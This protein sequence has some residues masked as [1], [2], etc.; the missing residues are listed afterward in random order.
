MVTFLCACAPVQS[1]ANNEWK[2]PVERK[3]EVYLNI[4]TTNKFIYNMT[5]ELTKDKHYVGYMF[6]NPLQGINFKYTDDSLN[7]ISKQD[8]FIYNGVGLEP[9][10]KD[11][12]NGL[13]KSKV[14]LTSISRG[15]KLI[16]YK[17]E[18]KYGKRT[19]KDNP[20]YWLNIDDYKISIL[21]IK[22]ALQDKDPRNNTYYEKNFLEHLKN[23]EPYEKD[24]KKTL[25]NLKKYTIFFGEEELEYFVRYS[26]LKDIN[27]MVF[28]DDKDLEEKLSKEENILFMYNNSQE[29][30]KN[31][32]IIKKYNMYTVKIRVYE[33]NFTYIDLLK[34][35]LANLKNIEEKKE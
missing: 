17:E 1:T 26:E 29:L 4:M 12:I 32:D 21:N 9:W 24:L 2:K 22:N 16:S 14:G 6:K 5:K 35:N 30:E 7:N 23:I 33:E 10:D 3:E 34:S 8:L 11:F 13:N 25:E 27:K 19:L 18:K 31:K 15:V 20:Y 28:K